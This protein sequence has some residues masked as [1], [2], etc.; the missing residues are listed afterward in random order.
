MGFRCEREDSGVKVCLL[1]EITGTGENDTVTHRAMHL[2]LAQV[3]SRSLQRLY[4][5]R[6]GSEC[7]IMGQPLPGVDLLSNKSLTCIFGF[8]LSKSYLKYGCKMFG[9]GSN[10]RVCIDAIY[11]KSTPGVV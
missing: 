2:N 1:M 10:F 11:S 5:H 9:Q 8:I 7:L 3:T 4:C 6:G